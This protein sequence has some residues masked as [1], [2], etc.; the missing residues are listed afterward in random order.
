[1]WKLNGIS[2]GHINY[3]YYVNNSLPYAFFLKEEFKTPSLSLK[4][5]E[6]IINSHLS[7]A[8]LKL[9]YVEH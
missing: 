4:I 1:M 3:Y 7:H 9:N 8:L 5:S 6:Y 2:H